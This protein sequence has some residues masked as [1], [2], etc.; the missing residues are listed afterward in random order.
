MGKINQHL[1]GERER[2]KFAINYRAAIITLTEISKALAQGGGR[3]WCSGG[4]TSNVCIE[5]RE[6]Y[7][8]F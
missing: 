5:I 7:K 4:V 2:K 8:K 1:D 6:F 3:E